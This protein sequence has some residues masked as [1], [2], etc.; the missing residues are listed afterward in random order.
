MKEIQ[1]SLGLTYVFIAH[2]LSVVKYMID[3]IIVMYLGRVVEDAGKRE[4]YENPMHPYTKALLSAI[5]VP[6]LGTKK[7]RIILEGDV[8]SP[9]HKPDGCPF[10]TRC[11]S[12]MAECAIV[13]PEL[14]SPSQGHKVACHLYGWHGSYAGTQTRQNSNL[15]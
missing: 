4:L 11:A 14:H 2:D 9:V 10:H 7:S 1:R 8:P 5:P 12:R 13:E 3:R 6:V 15:K